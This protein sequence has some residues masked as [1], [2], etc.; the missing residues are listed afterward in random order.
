MLA[1]VN[2]QVVRAN[3]G[4]N[5]RGAHLRV[6]VAKGPAIV[7]V[8][9]GVR[10]VWSFLGLFRIWDWASGVRLCWE[11]EEPKRPKGRK[12]PD[13][14]AKER[15]ERREQRKEEGKEEGRKEGRDEGTEER[16]DSVKEGPHQTR[17]LRRGQS[18]DSQT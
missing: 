13:G 9:P 4:F 7:A 18:G 1:C 17:S 6:V 11:L 5:F 10:R 2:F 3:L 12:E 8:F 16:R 15:R 14:S